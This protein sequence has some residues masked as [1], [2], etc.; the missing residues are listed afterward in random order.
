MAFSDGGYNKGT[1]IPSLVQKTRRIISSVGNSGTS[2][3][4]GFRPNIADIGS[5][6]KLLRFDF[7]QLFFADVTLKFFYDAVE[8]KWNFK[9]LKSAV[10]CYLLPLFL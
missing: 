5:V 9:D 2:T 10:R 8:E 4:H 7:L 1:G 6:R 3:D